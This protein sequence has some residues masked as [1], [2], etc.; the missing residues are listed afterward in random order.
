MRQNATKKI[1]LVKD[2]NFK[3]YWEWM[4]LKIWDYKWI[5]SI[6]KLYVKSTN[7]YKELIYNNTLNM[8]DECLK[9]LKL[10]N[11]MKS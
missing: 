11:L 1:V 7:M 6:T 10:M 2:L 9:Y 5:Y 4:F 8:E 3:P